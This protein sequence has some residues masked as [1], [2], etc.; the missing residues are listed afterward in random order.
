VALTRWWDFLGP[1]RPPFLVLT[2]ACVLLGLGTAVWTTGGAVDPVHFL[3]VLAGA[4]AAHVSVNAFNEYFDFRSGLDAVTQRTP[5]SGGSGT[6]VARPE[7]AVPTLAMAVAALAITAAVGLY[8][9]SIRGMAL[10][11]LGLLGMVVIVVYTPWLTHSP[12]LCLVAAG[13]GFGPLMVVGTDFVLT[14]SYSKTA[15]VAS[16]VP[17]FLV[18]NLLL[19]NQFPDVEADRQAGRRT[20]PIS[21]GRRASTLVYG[22]FVLLACLALAA[23]IASHLLPIASLA[24][25]AGLAVA[26]AAFAGAFRYSDQTG[27]L[28]PYM[29][30]NV[31]AN[32]L[33]PLLI[34]AGLLYG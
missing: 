34:A 22:A 12:L 11:P 28:I 2:P 14:G 8:F 13:L 23:G 4:L 25:L 24:G 1:A 21:I 18:N 20:L 26:M 30:M 29:G 17:F 3:L 33:T 32:I 15:L 5:F 27:K 10:M 19:L 6:L 16:L 7:L 31:A 9:I